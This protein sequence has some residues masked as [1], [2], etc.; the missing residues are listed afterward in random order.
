MDKTIKMPRSHRKKTENTQNQKVSPTEDASSP[1]VTEQGLMENKCEESSELGFRSRIDQAEERILEVEDQLKEMKREDQIRE[2]RVKRN[3][4]NLQEIW[5]YV[6]R[7]NLR[8]IGIP[9]SDK[10]NESKLEN[11]FQGIIQENFPKL[12][13]HDNT[14]LQ[15]IQR[16]PQR[17]SSRRP[18]PRHH[19]GRPRQMDHLRSEVQDQ[20]SQHG[21]TPSLLK[22][23][24]L[25]G[26]GVLDTAKS[27]RIT[28]ISEKQN[29]VATL[30]FRVNQRLAHECVCQ[31]VS[32][33]VI[34]LLKPWQDGIAVMEKYAKC[35]P[36]STRCYVAKHFCNELPLSELENFPKSTDL[37]LGCP[38]ELSRGGWMQWLTPVIPALGTWEAKV[39]GSP[40]VR[41]SRPAWPTW[42]NPISTK[43]TKN[44][45]RHAREEAEAGGSLEVRS[46]RPAWPTWGNPISTKNI[47]IS[48]HFGRPRQVDSLSLGSRDQPGQHGETPFL[49]K[50]QKLARHGGGHLW[51]QLLGRLRQEDHMS[52]GGRGCSNKSNQKQIGFH[53]IDQAGLELLISGD[54]PTSAS[55]SAGITGVS[56]RARLNPIFKS[57]LRCWDYRH[58]PPH[59]ACVHTLKQEVEEKHFKQEGVDRIKCYLPTALWEAEAG[60]SLELRSLRPA[61]P[62]W[63]NP[64]FTKNT[65]ISQ[66]WWYMSVV[67]AT[68]RAGTGESLEPR[69]QLSR[70]GTVAHT[71]NP[72]TLGGQSRQ[73]TSSRD[74]GHPGQ[75]SETPSLLKIEK[76]AGHRES[77]FIQSFNI[78][79]KQGLTLLPRLDYSDAI[80]AHCNLELQGSSNPPTSA[81]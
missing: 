60:R 3:E 50:I 13:S 29:T 58:E 37:N 53:H 68:H 41:S 66:V 10:E 33:D 73:I 14:Q 24:K 64:I 77:K 69:R 74:Q 21:K 12:A 28:M 32:E 36:H 30:L 78:F 15:A 22:T 65:K 70:P 56:H 38:L 1:S 9:E 11:I 44:L 54:P 47:K 59:P 61:W 31:T 27:K 52:L 57:I 67:P 17:Y 71:C 45:A 81:S 20:P 51:S 8:L 42:R 62:T 46:S 75:H 72:S 26:R 80:I 39:G 2:K 48:Q 49:S 79:L 25:A 4:Q 40:E 7:P 23:Q 19:S 6:K 18:T 5:D 34:I 43:N 35:Q 55:Q 16:T 63:Q 76:L